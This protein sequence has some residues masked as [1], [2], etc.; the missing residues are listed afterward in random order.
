MKKTLLKLATI[1]F[2]AGFY[3]FLVTG[4]HEQFHMVAA[5]NLGVPGYVIFRLDWGFFA[6]ISPETLTIFQDVI[7]G[8]AG[9]LGVA[10]LFGVAWA[11]Q[12]WQGHDSESELDTA[13]I[14]A[15]IT[16][17]QFLYAISEGIEIW[18]DWFGIWSQLIGIFAGVAVMFKLYG[19]QLEK[20]LEGE[21]I[22]PYYR[23]ARSLLVTLSERTKKGE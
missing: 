6:Y 11:I 17:F 12:H 7:I 1:L 13:A 10:F 5:N 20:W 18:A 21:S 22:I 15:I 2:Q 14:F 4:S 23:K 3:F 16:T 8:L 9:G 19:R